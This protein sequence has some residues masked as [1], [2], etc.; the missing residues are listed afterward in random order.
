MSIEEL[1]F[2]GC[3]VEDPPPATMADVVGLLCECLPIAI[4]P[5][6]SKSGMAVTRANIRAKSDG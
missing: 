4:M 6:D 1:V 5:V 3:V 2:D